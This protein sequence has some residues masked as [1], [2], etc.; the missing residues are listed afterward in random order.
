MK[1]NYDAMLLIRFQFARPNEPFAFAG[2]TLSVYA[3]SIA[4]YF[5]ADPHYNVVNTFFIIIDMSLHNYLQWNI[6]CLLFSAAVVTFTAENGKI[7][8]SFTIH[9]LYAITLH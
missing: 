4:K 8:I 3:R 6:Y 9:Q 2:R 1:A 7:S 5:P